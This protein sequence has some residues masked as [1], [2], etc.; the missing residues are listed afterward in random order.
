MKNTNLAVSDM[1]GSMQLHPQWTCTQE[2]GCSPEFSDQMKALERSEGGPSART[3]NTATQSC[4]ETTIPSHLFRVLLLRRL[5]QPLPFT[6]RACRCG[7][8]LDVYATMQHVLVLG[9]GS[10]R[11]CSGKCNC[12]NLPRGWWARAHQHCGCPWR[13]PNW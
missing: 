2:R 8:L 13:G 6:G 9:V 10:T 11:V 3:P 12:T 7:R 4:Q 5:R 1:D